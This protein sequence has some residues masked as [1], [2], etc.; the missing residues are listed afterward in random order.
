MT[1]ELLLVI[2]AVIDL[3]AV[4]FAAKL[5]RRWLFATIAANLIL[6]TV[7]GSKLISVGSMTTNAG[8]VF[9]ACVFFATHLLLEQKH[10]KKAY[11]TIWFGISFVLFFTIMARIVVLMTSATPLDPVSEHIAFLFPLGVR[12]MVASLVS[13]S[14][15]QSINIFLYQFAGQK[16]L[17]RAW[18]KSLTA[19]IFAQL[20]DS[21]LFFSIAFPDL[22]AHSLISAIVAGWIIKVCVGILGIPYLSRYAQQQQL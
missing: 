22:S 11:Q 13:Y 8:N 1:N 3:T 10:N 16:I 15:A 7:F 21:A 12:V 9:Y 20:F 4:F 17:N 18:F 14:F 6:I 19:T 5:G 2:S